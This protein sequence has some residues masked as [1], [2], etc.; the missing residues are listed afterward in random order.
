M[1]LEDFAFKLELSYNAML[2]EQERLRLFEEA[3]IVKAKELINQFYP[4]DIQTLTAEGYR[5]LENKLKA[6]CRWMVSDIDNII[7]DGQE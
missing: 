3:L 7:D 2:K 6:K 4:E 1:D 5:T